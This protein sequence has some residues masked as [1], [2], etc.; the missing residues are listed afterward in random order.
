MISDMSM[1]I[2]SC[3]VWLCSLRTSTWDNCN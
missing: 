1:I 2:I 3:R